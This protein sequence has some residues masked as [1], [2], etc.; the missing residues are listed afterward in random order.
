MA[1]L[2]SVKTGKRVH[3]LRCKHGDDLRSVAFAD[4]GGTAVAAGII[5]GGE[6]F[7]YQWTTVDGRPIPSFTNPSRRLSDATCL[8]LAPN[9]LR[10]VAGAVR[11]LGEGDWEV[12]DLGGRITGG[13]VLEIWTVDAGHRAY[14]LEEEELLFGKMQIIAIGP[15]SKR[16]LASYDNGILALWGLPM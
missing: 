13:D 11:R 15:E 6:L 3:K 14:A 5:G 10:I 12:H 4:N 8:C 9:G 1:A 16:A 7:A 2:W